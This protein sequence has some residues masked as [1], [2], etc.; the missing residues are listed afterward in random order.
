VARPS[1][2]R[3]PR[4][5]HQCAA[6]CSIRRP[7]LPSSDGRWVLHDWRGNTFRF[8]VCRNSIQ[9]A[10]ALQL[11]VSNHWWQPHD[12]Q[13][14]GGGERRARSGRCQP[15]RRTTG[16]RA[17]P[18]VSNRAG[19][20]LKWCGDELDPTVFYRHRTP[21][22]SPGS[23]SRRFCPVRGGFP[24]LRARCRKAALN[25]QGTRGARRKTL[26]R[27]QL[28]CLS[29]GEWFRTGLSRRLPRP[30]TLRGV[31]V[32]EVRSES[33]AYVP[34]A[35]RGRAAPVTAEGSRAPTSRDCGPIRSHPSE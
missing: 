10:M 13:S 14:P 28:E 29:F 1:G 7:R 21:S 9:S 5:A 27:S 33:F 34:R 20:R 24:E 30:A 11:P 6:R 3:S 12:E 22:E 19:V 15:A 2:P 4:S 35:R 16:R 32:P 23:F 18:D 17:F 8:V 31:S 25:E 26:N